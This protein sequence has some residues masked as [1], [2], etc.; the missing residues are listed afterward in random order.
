MPICKLRVNE[1]YQHKYFYKCMTPKNNFSRHIWRF[2]CFFWVGPLPTLLG[3]LP[4]AEASTSKSRCC[5]W[6]LATPIAWRHGPSWENSMNDEILRSNT[7]T[8]WHMMTHDGTLARVEPIWSLDSR[9]EINPLMSI[10]S[11][12]GR[13]DWK[14]PKSHQLH[15]SGFVFSF[16]PSFSFDCG[17]CKRYKSTFPNPWCQTNGF[18]FCHHKFH[19]KYIAPPYPAPFEKEQ[20]NQSS[21]EI[22]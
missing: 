22:I 16:F 20:P 10:V 3:A 8:W 18:F 19:S 15:H 4:I 9:H 14:G 12:I 17:K 7:G 2:S 6:A 13:H 5:A 21:W 11:L 1:V